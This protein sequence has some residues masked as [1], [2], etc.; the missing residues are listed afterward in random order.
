M[1]SAETKLKSINDRIHQAV[2]R[3]NQDSKITLIG[4][5]KGHSHNTIIP[6]IK[7][8]LK[9][10][11][12][13]YI[14]EAEKKIPYLPRN[15]TK[16]FIGRLQR[17]KIKK[18]LQIFDTLVLYRLTVILELEKRINQFFSS[19]LPHS[20]PNPFPV[21]IQVNLANDPSKAGC[22]PNQTLNFVERINDECSF[23]KCIG[24]MTIAPLNIQ[25]ETDLRN[26]YQRMKYLHEEIQS[27]FPQVNELSMGMSNSFEIAIEEGSTMVRVGTEL[28]GYRNL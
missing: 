27:S 1:S 12:E 14:Q 22:L 3:A 17:N 5:S 11:G 4:A 13:S 6:Y 8:G 20:I 16:H 28:F 10:I 26:F 25:R 19:S 23:L 21:L 15:I 24:L 2:E 18:A 9:N 7:A